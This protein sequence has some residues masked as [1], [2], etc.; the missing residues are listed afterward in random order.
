MR[1]SDRIA[2]AREA[3]LAVARGYVTSK[4]GFAR[5]LTYREMVD[6]AREACDA[7]GWSYY[8][9]VSGTRGQA[10]AATCVSREASS[11]PLAPDAGEAP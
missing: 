10:P 11:P 4:S 6:G 7:L 5:K 8:P 2:L 3:L 1:P 9:V